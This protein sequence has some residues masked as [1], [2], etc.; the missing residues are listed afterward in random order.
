MK[1]SPQ[2]RSKQRPTNFKENFKRIVYKLLHKSSGLN[3][4]DSYLSPSPDSYLT[5]F[6]QIGF[7]NQQNI[8]SNKLK[9]WRG[10]VE[11]GTLGDDWGQKRQKPKSR[12]RISSL[13]NG[14]FH[15]LCKW[16]HIIDE[17]LDLV[18]C[19]LFKMAGERGLHFSMLALDI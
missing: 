17:S 15:F 7:F 14:W 16:P 8:R 13:L 11:A 1:H 10:P 9:R 19:V 18:Q 2:S 3:S 12:H 6:S 4:L 5:Y